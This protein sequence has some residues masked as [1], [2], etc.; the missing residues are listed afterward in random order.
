MNTLPSTNPVRRLLSRGLATGLLVSQLAPML[1]AQTAPAKPDAEPAAKKETAE[2]VVRLDKF[3]VTAGFSGSLAAAAEI[4]QKQT[5]VAEVI[6]A[7]DI[8]KLPDIS[9]AES[10]TRLPGVTTQRL[11]GRAQAIVIRGM[12]G[13]FSTGL[14]NGREQVS[15]GAGRSVEY[16]QYPAELLTGVVVYKA[17]DASL[18]GQGLAGT[19]DMQTVRPLSAGKRTVAANAFYEWN[20]LGAVNAGAKDSGHR[21]TFSYVDQFAGGK[22]GVALGYSTSDR[23]G[24]GYQWNA[25][26][27]PNIGASNTPFVLGGAKPFVRTSQI[28]RDGTV[29]VIE[30]APY[31]KV[32]STIDLFYSDFQETQL[33][34]GIEIPLYWSSAVLQP[35]YI[36]SNGL[37]TQGTFNNIYGVARNDYVKRNDHLFSGGW[38]IEFGDAKGWKTDVDISY[39]RVK[40]KDFVLETYSGYASNQVGTPDTLT[41]TLGQGEGGAIFTKKLD[42]A[43]ASLM[44]LTSPQGWASGD[45]PGGQVGFVKGPFSRDKIEAYKIKTQHPLEHFFSRVE[46]GLSLSERSKYEYEAG[47]GGQEGYFLALKNGATSA[48]LPASVGTTD[49][50][51]IGMGNLYSYD[52]IALYNSGYYD[53]KPNTNPSYVSNNWDVN[54]KVTIAYAKLDIDQKMGSVGV[55]GNIGAQYMHTEQVSKGLAANGTIITKVSGKHTYDDVLPSANLNFRLGGGKTLRVSAARQLARQR[56]ND[57]RAGSTY[58]YNQSL[59]SSTDPLKSAWSGSGGNPDLEPRRS[60]SYD[61]SFENYFNDNMGYWAIAAFHKDLVSYTYNQT[62]IVDYTGYPT[63]LPAGSTGSTPATFKGTS[64]VPQ[65]GQGGKIEGLEFALSLP[66]EKFTQILK[67]FGFIGSASFF[68]SSVQP[69][70][71]NP[72]TPL[73][74]LSERV[75]TGT[76]YYEAKNGFA[77][78]ISTRYRSSYRGDISTFGPRGENFRNLQAETNIDAQISYAFKKG[79]LKGLTLIA[80][81]YN[82]NN[83]PLKASQGD[84]TRLVQDYQKYGSSYSVGASYKF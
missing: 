61:L 76:I 67:G 20:S 2:E 8:G 23:P 81:G 75:T 33:L 83:E 41:Y 48:P 9:I 10:L 64:T 46:G 58:G 52:P 37:V 62:K 53:L 45:V 4:K 49:L 84:D 27:Y 34:R 72:S 82:L 50:S 78:R 12:N 1:S 80:Q 11:N 28:K 71:S 55:T 38:N 69:D 24:Q 31:E 42:Y 40:R 30:L 15:T 44:R 14:L 43:N 26:G 54:E 60:N 36:V 73:P 56:M 59:A 16:D 17:T 74:G 65:N 22:V 6:A 13:D 5:L 18:M 47:P 39:S 21:E 35:G 63:G 29:A 68:D 79:A 7:E 57:M 25:W 32:H 51:F 19:V 70:L 3:E 66:G 77:A